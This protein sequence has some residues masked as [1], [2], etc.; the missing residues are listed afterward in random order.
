MT[1]NAGRYVVELK[2]LGWWDKEQVNAI[3]LSATKL[4]SGDIT[5]IDG[6][7]I[8]EARK[9]EMQL[10]I[11]SI[12]EGENVVLFTDGWLGQLT[13]EEG[14]ALVAAIAEMNKKK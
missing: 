10:M 1:V 13:A 12:K 9:R 11:A 3:R 4:T 5:G 6:I 8:I 2:E 14:K 7:V